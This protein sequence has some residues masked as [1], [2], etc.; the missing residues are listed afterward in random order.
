MNLIDLIQQLR[1]RKRRVERTIAALE[2]IWEASPG[3]G[4]SPVSRR[5]R[6]GMPAQERLEV[7]QRMK[8]YWAEWRRKQGKKPALKPRTPKRSTRA[9]NR[10]K[11]DSLPTA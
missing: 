7:S 3:G 6:K 4:S 9:S 1:E 8:E 10:R 5:G 2:A 11:S